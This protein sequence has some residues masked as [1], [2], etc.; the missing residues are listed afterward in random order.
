MPGRQ[1]ALGWIMR[2]RHNV[3]GSGMFNSAFV[4]LAIA[5]FLHFFG[6]QRFITI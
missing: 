2:Y 3:V 4:K 1:N 6:P 5:A